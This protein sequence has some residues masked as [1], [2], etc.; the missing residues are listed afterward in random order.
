MPDTIALDLRARREA[1]IRAHADAENRR[2]VAATLK[3]FHKRATRSCRSA[4]PSTAPAMC[5][6]C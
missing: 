4:S 3:T 1:V 5:T 6:S 2:D